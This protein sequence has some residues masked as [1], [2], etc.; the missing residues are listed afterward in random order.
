MNGGIMK[1]KLKLEMISKVAVTVSALIYGSRL[2]YRKDYMQ[3]VGIVVVVSSLYWMFNRDY[4]LPFLGKCLMPQNIIKDMTPVMV[5]G[6]IPVKLTGLP[7]NT[8]VIYWA[9]LKSNVA[10]DDPES[11]YGNYLNS[12]ITQTNNMGDAYARID[13]PSNYK[14]GMFKTKLDKH[15]HYRYALREYKGLYSPVFTVN[16]DC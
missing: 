13:C 12:G 16:V 9:S 5:D 2:M 10:I 8:Q 1:I 3:I 6:K 7:P 15:L 14:V 11:A 4:Y